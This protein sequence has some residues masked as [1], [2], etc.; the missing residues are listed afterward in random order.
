MI[1]SHLKCLN[2]T[3]N[4]KCLY[5]CN[6]MSI[7]HEMT[8]YLKTQIGLGIFYSNSRISL[9]KN[10]TKFDAADMCLFKMDE[11]LKVFT[12]FCLLHIC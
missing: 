3:M 4:K 10:I 8:S 2:P 11:F 9:K 12:F 1:V 7:I 6:S 5:L